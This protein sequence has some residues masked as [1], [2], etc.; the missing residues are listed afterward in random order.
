MIYIKFLLRPK[1]RLTSIPI[2]T[3]AQCLT[4]IN[5]PQLAWFYGSSV[6]TRSIWEIVGCSMSVMGL[7]SSWEAQGSISWFTANIYLVVSHCGH[8]IPHVAEQWNYCRCI[9]VYGVLVLKGLIWFL[10]FL[11]WLFTIHG[12]SSCRHL[13]GY[14]QWYMYLNCTTL[15]IYLVIFPLKHI[16][17]FFMCM[18]S[19]ITP[20]IKL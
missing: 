1:E 12:L 9:T 14:I 10:L 15:H 5:F 4:F 8:R 2:S 20:I 16:A 17:L 18:T 3:H 19:F 13:Y 11:P 6:L 7:S